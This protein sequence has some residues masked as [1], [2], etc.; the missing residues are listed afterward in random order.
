MGL[1]EKLGLALNKDAPAD[2]SLLER[3]VKLDR[4]DDDRRIAFGFAYVARAAPTTKGMELQRV[5]DHSGE[6]MEPD[7]LERAAYDF[8]LL[9]R[10][11]DEE[12][13][14][15][16]KADLIESVVF[17]EEKLRRWATDG[18]GAVDEG[19]LDVLKATFGESWWTGWRIREPG[20]GE[21]D[22]W[23]RVKS[24]ELGM[25]SIGGYARRELVDA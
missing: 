12:H 17:T 11:G 23:P 24:G 15:A 5:V 16:V 7:V 18:D 19:R 3:V 8:N 22:M 20:E 10:E 25:L 6:F 1:L 14:S 2:P 9:Y 4:F 13:T 21:D